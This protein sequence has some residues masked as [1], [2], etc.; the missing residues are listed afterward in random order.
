MD[1]VRKLYFVNVLLKVI[2]MRC[3]PIVMIEQV[4]NKRNMDG[5]FSFRL[6][7][8]IG[9]KTSFDFRIMDLLCI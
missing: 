9:L 3:Q 5:M 2:S 7:K 4:P 1:L 6:N 8:K